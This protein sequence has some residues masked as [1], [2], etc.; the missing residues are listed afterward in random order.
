[1][2]ITARGFL[3]AA[4]S[5]FGQVIG[6]AVPL[7]NTRYSTSG[8]AAV[9]TLASNGRTFVAA[10]RT[11]TGVRVSRVDG[12]K[13]SIGVPVGGVTA[14]A[15]AITAHGSGYVMADG[16]ALQFFDANGV[17]GG[18]SVIG[19]NIKRARI[20]SNGSAIMIAYPNPAFA[21]EVF[22]AFIAGSGE[23]LQKDVKIGTNTVDGS[24]LPFAV[25]ADA[26]GFAFISEDNA[27]I[28]L[29]MF[30]MQGNLR[31]TATLD[32]F[33]TVA[34]YSAVAGNG[35]DFLAVWT[36]DEHALRGVQFRSDTNFVGRVTLLPPREG[37]AVTQPSLAFDGQSY[38]CSYRD[39][40]DVDFIRI[41]PETLTVSEP[42]TLGSAPVSAPS[43]AG[44]NGIAVPAWSR[45]AAT[46]N[47]LGAGGVVYARSVS[48]SGA[49]GDPFSVSNGAHDQTFAAAATNGVDSLVAWIEGNGQR[50]QM[51]AGLLRADGTW[52]ELG[53]L[54]RGTI[55]PLV[56]SD[57]HDFLVIGADG[58]LRVPADGQ[59]IDRTPI[60]L[61]HLY[62]TG[63][64]W[65]GHEY[66]VVGEIDHGALNSP[67][68]GALSI[69]AS[70]T[71]GALHNIRKPVSDDRAE[72]PS[73]VS[74]GSDFMVTFTVFEPPING[75]FFFIPGGSGGR[76]VRLS[77][78]LDPVGAEIE[79]DFVDVVS[80]TAIAWNG[81]EYLA[82]AVDDQALDA[83]RLSPNGTI[84]GRRRINPD[85]KAKLGT[86]SVIAIGDDFYVA[87]REVGATSIASGAGFFCIVYPDGS[88]SALTP[89]PET[90]TSSAD[91]ILV[92][93][94]AGMHVIRSHFLDA[95]PYFG[96]ERLVINA[97]GITDPPEAPTLNLRTTS[98]T[99]LLLWSAAMGVNGYRIEYRNGLHDWQELETWQVPDARAFSLVFERTDIYQ[100]R[101]KA[102]GWGGASYSNVTT[103]DPTRRRVI[104]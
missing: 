64:V 65:S 9:A 36:D 92:G 33:T 83:V 12:A 45:G 55:A 76:A 24:P 3:L 91:P 48:A 10:W 49:L 62:P 96:A 6:S 11:P 19:T 97:I 54:G 72:R 85:E 25:A 21:F 87:W 41:A 59:I 35:R 29:K 34:R 50:V 26:N 67:G 32:G 103:F 53:A 95:P 23:V 81:S 17:P 57:G 40:D 16:N 75:G 90:R 42:V 5:A 61:D 73:I 100:F 43:I 30:D 18:R 56:A 28:R 15:P 2:R 51:M 86:P 13:A 22:G 70:G 104:R 60:P 44:A 47:N 80:S 93:T 8:E 46:L 99:G 101:V 14:D 82:L 68:L 20:A 78:S 58:A 4:S 1:M 7:T 94:A 66:V 98:D 52:R 38:V 89:F 39:G 77:Q 27:E 88:T 71:A 69:S 74:S 84:L 31:R 63:V 102:I 37:H 79:T